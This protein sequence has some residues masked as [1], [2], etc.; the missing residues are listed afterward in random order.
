MQ[1]SVVHHTEEYKQPLSSK[2]KLAIMETFLKAKLSRLVVSSQVTLFNTK[3]NV[4]RGFVNTVEL[5]NQKLVS[6]LAAENL[7]FISSNVTNV[8]HF[9]EVWNETTVI[10]IWTDILIS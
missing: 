2:F 8:C 1:L 6:G 9:F 3:T 10:S 5:K 7:S 4:I